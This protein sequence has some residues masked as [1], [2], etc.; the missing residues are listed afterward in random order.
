MGI[1]DRPR[2]LQIEIF[3]QVKVGWAEMRNDALIGP[4]LD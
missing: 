4:R 1:L 3:H 2:A